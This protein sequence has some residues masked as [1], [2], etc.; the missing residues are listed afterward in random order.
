MRVPLPLF[1]LGLLVGLTAASPL[2]FKDADN[3]VRK[4]WSAKRADADDMVRNS[5]SQ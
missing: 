3:L 1:V 5:W 4:S 2:A